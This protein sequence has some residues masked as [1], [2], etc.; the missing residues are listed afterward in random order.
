M[1]DMIAKLIE[2]AKQAT[3]GQLNLIIGYASRITTE[4]EDTSGDSNAIECRE[5]CLSADS[6]EIKSDVSTCLP[7]VL[8]KTETSPLLPCPHCG[9]TSVWHFG[10]KHDKARYRCKKCGKT[11]V[12]TT[13][14]TQYH[15]HSDSETWETLAKDTVNGISLKETAKTLGISTKTAF[16]MRHKL[17]MTLESQETP[18]TVLHGECELDE[19]YVLES[20]KGT[21]IPE[22]WRKPRKH[23]AIA[24]K[25][26]LSNEQVCIITGIE[27]TEKAY[28][29]TKNTAPP[30]KA[31]IVSAFH[32]HL[33]EGSHVFCDGAANYDALF[34]ECGCDVTH[35]HPHGINTVNGFHSF[36]KQFYNNTYHGVATKYINR[37][38]AL[39]ATVY[40]HKEDAIDKLKNLLHTNLGTNWFTVASIKTWNLFTGA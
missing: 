8:A 10:K 1:S 23:G 40:R 20:H 33:A 13:N 30:S 34:D 18:N 11:Y 19:T 29:T 2:I 21:S 27:R 22:Y 31:E 5:V 9:S 4:K 35:T 15:S 38:N 3:E 37:Y 28:A 25:R 26:G 39:F 32:E 12:S 36:I 24:E 16:R 14:T 7:T 6:H 17:L